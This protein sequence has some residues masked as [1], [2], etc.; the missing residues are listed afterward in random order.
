M[1][2]GS[3]NNEIKRFEESNQEYNYLS[4]KD[5]TNDEI[6]YENSEEG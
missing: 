2:P 6:F 1:F 5:S 4:D 3:F